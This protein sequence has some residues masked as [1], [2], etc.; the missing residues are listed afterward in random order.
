MINAHK[1]YLIEITKIYLLCCIKLFKEFKKCEHNMVSLNAIAEAKPRHCYRVPN[2][3]KN[4][5]SVSI[6]G[7]KRSVI[8]K[9]IY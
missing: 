7:H 6:N 8:R 3:S 1:I 2:W 9:V 4:F 5:Q